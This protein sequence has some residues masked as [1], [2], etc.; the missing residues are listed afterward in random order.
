MKKNLLTKSI[1]ERYRAWR[2]DNGNRKPNRI[3]V[4]MHWEDEDNPFQ[5][6][7]IDTI[8]IVPKRMNGFTEEIP[9]DALILF[10]VSSL[11]GLLALIEPGNG[12]DFVV[13]EVVEFYRIGK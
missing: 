3:V 9:G 8:A 10:Y 12:S 11:D 1:I 13:D 2:R 4:K 5:E 7:Q 6:H